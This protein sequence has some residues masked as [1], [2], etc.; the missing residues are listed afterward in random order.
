[1]MEHIYIFLFESLVF[2]RHIKVAIITPHTF[3]P[4][5][6]IFDLFLGKTGTL[7]LSFPIGWSAF[8]ILL[9]LF[10]VVLVLQ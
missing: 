6:C 9:V 3:I 2:H 1:M 5:M 10:K 7:I 4:R 8:A